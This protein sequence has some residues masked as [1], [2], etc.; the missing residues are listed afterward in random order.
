[1]SYF[2]TIHATLKPGGYWVNFGPLLWGTAP[3]VQLSLDEI[4]TITQSMGFEFVDT[5]DACGEPTSEGMSVRG[6][7]AVYGFNERALTR[8]VFSAQFW[9]ARKVI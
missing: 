2:D 5:S 6:K 3:F 7:R 9:V 1:M 4:V 8:N